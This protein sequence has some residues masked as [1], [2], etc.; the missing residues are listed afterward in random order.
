MTQYGKDFYGVSTRYEIYGTQNQRAEQPQESNSVLSSTSTGSTTTGARAYA[1]AR[2]SDAKDDGR[3]NML[4]GQYQDACQYYAENFRRSITPVIQRQLAELIRD[5]M[6]VDVI[7]MAIDETQMAPRPSWA[8]CA[9]I[10]RR[11]ENSGIRTLAQW[12]EDKRQYAS[13]LNPALNYE[14]RRYTDDD[15]GPDFFTIP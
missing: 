13:R 4:Y 8:Y 15:Y 9:A 7:R 5:G 2:V 10:L 12:Q 1:C 11:C 3:A 6:S 14:Q